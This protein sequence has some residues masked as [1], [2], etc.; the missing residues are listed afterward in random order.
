MNVLESWVRVS[1][2]DVPLI[3]GQTV[4]LYIEPGNTEL[5]VTSLYPYRPDATDDEACKSKTLKL[6]LTPNQNR[7]FLICPAIKGDHYACGW[8]ISKTSAG[9]GDQ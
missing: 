7:T 2:Y 4:C 5:T 6:T 3:G 1:D 8:T 9:C